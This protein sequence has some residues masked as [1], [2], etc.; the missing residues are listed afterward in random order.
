M[1]NVW[2]SG[3]STAWSKNALASG[4]TITKT[5]LDN[6]DTGVYSAT[7]CLNDLLYTGAKSTTAASNN[8]AAVHNSYFRGKNL[9]TSF[10]SEQAATIASGT[11]DDMFIGDYWTL[12][13]TLGSSSANVVYEIAAFDY[14]L[15][16]G[17]TNCAT[18]HIVLVPRSVLYSAPMNSTNT[19][20]GGYVGSAMYTEE[21][22]TVSG[23]AYT[24]L[25]KAR[26]GIEA[27]FGDY[28]VTK[29]L[30]LSNAV[31]NGMES[32][33]AWVD[34][35]VD[36]MTESMV[37]GSPICRAM[38][39]GGTMADTRTTEK[40]QLPLF[41]FK[42]NHRVSFWLQDVCSA[43]YFAYCYHYGYATRTNATSVFGVRPAFAVS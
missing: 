12:T 22:I 27:L 25:A 20:T 2:S 42:P 14:Y 18:H 6:T 31:S 15:G 24:G 11:F 5:A 19:T 36:L 38:S 34:S 3:I 13:T 32:A 39:Y 1:S 40:T 10:T 28:L 43:S 21:E 4:A 9:G 33:R 35:T 23:V 26:S 16:T 7:R 17:D 29:R 30:F 41:F 37:Y 8:M